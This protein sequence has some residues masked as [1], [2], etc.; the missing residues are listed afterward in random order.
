MT[1]THT[2]G[3]RLI[4]K[5]KN[6]SWIQKSAVKQWLSQYKIKFETEMDAMDLRT[7]SRNYSP[8]IIPLEDINQGLL[9]LL[10]PNFE[11]HMQPE[12]DPLQGTPSLPKTTAAVMAPQFAWVDWG[13]LYL[14][15]IFQRDVSAKHVTKLRRSWDPTAVLIP[16]AIKITI[17]S[18]VYICIWDGH[19]TL[20]AMRIMNYTRFPVWYVDIDAVP[21][22]V[23]T[24]AGF[25]D[26]QAGRVKYG[27]WLAGRNMILINSTNK[28]ALDP[29]DRFMIQLE[30]LDA[31]ALE[32][33]RILKATGCMAKRHAKTPGSWTQIKSGEECYDL[34]TSNGMPS[35]GMFWKHALEF[36]RKLWPNAAL[37]LEVFR[38]LSYLYQAFDQGSYPLDAEFD[39][40][41]AN[42][43]AKEYGPPEAVH[44]S[45]KDSHDRAVMMNLGRGVM[46]QN[47]REIVVSG[48]INLYNQ[49]C[50]R[51]K[52]IPQADYVW[53]V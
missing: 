53:V 29:Y 52:L 40:E 2:A 26:D 33:D 12:Y 20:Q 42:L 35:K 50:G 48:L 41:L 39:Q 32:M 37:E 1:S 19:H 18:K 9:A 49:K 30:T 15:S 27:C 17:N 14:W 21:S 51:L 4:N 47:H 3:T 34:K 23:I 6:N 43:L 16:C 11:P 31:K 45:I 8:E 22:S 38:P 44:L 5:S 10:G 13:D 28:M 24:A 7:M 25:T 46:L 36:H